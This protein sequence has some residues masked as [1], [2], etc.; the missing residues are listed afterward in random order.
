MKVLTS[1]VNNP[2]FIEI[3]HHTLKKFLNC[4][5][6]FI[7][8]NDAKPFPDFT[9]G[10]DATLHNKIGET[11]HRLSL[12]CIPV[13]N[14]HHQYMD[15]PVV[16]CAEAMNFMYKY[17]LDNVDEYLIID[18]DMFPIAHIDLDHYRWY[19]CAIV[20][21]HRDYVQPFDY[22]WNGLFYFNMHIMDNLHDI[23]WDKCYNADVGGMTFKWL[24]NKCEHL[25]STIDIRHSPENQFNRNGIYFIKHFWSLTWNGSEMPEAFKQ[26]PIDSFI[27]ADPRN[28]DGRYFCEIYDNTFLHY[29][30]GGDWQRRGLGFHNDLSE[31]LKAVLM[32]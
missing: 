12:Q 27:G 21:Q 2:L 5:Y 32:T 24:K 26:T 17:M 16:R 13:P 8:F 9:N 20:L 30:A 11:C 15:C 4:D 28:K 29:R 6:E 1:V 18:S 14:Q 23:K 25:P 3:Q 10:G 7:V 22:I 19:D 31:K